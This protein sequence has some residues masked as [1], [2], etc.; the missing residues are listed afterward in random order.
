MK[1]ALMLFVGFTLANAAALLP[2]G[3]LALIFI[4]LF[5]GILKA[6]AALFHKAATTTTETEVES[7]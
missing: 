6:I 3:I 7:V 4:A 1:L 2:P 5:V